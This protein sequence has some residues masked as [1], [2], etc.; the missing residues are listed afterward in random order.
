MFVKLG[1]GQT[2]FSHLLAIRKERYI[3][4]KCGCGQLRGMQSNFCFQ[5]L[6]HERTVEGGRVILKA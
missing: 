5:S 1:L 6:L 3:L 4:R 2:G